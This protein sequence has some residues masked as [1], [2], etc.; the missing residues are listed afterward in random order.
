VTDAEKIEQIKT[1][2]G[3][4]A[5]N[6]NKGGVAA[7]DILTEIMN[8]LEFDP[9]SDAPYK[10]AISVPCSPCGDG[11]TALEYHDHDHVSVENRR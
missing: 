7:M 8:L 6:D 4:W 5:N 11:D 1:W 3:E 10:G 2:I 9:F